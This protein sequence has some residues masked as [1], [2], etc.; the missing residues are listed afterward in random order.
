MAGTAEECKKTDKMYV[1]WLV[2]HACYEFAVAACNSTPPFIGIGFLSAIVEG[3]V[4][5]LV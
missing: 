1:F 4:T 5:C 3:N 2:K